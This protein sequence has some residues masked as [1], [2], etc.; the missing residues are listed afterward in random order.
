MI[1]I[2]SQ[3]S[4]LWQLSPSY[5]ECHQDIVWNFDPSIHNRL[6]FWHGHNIQPLANKVSEMT[7]QRERDKVPIIPRSAEVSLSIDVPKCDVTANEVDGK[8]CCIHYV[9][10]MKWQTKFILFIILACIPGSGDLVLERL[11]CTKRCIGAQCHCRKFFLFFT[12]NDD[13]YSPKDQ[14]LL[15]IEPSVTEKLFLFCASTNDE[16]QWTHQLT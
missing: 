16:W 4:T 1:I 3:E 11:I 7:D 14:L 6:K 15:S 5:G 10:C 9:E 2:T 13:S 12:S 8:P